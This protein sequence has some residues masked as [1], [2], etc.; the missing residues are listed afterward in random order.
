M[1]NV[2]VFTST[3]GMDVKKAKEVAIKLFK[4]LD[5]PEDTWN[6]R[7]KYISGGEKKRLSMA[8]GLIHEP[9]VLFLDEP[10]TFFSHLN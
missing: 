10:T 5:I 4:I 2:E 1:V 8:L 7:V 6:K 3:Y 9:D